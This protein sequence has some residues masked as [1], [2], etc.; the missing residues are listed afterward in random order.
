M[1][2]ATSSLNSQ[3]IPVSAAEVEMED[4]GPTIGTLRVVEAGTEETIS[5]SSD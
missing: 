1:S 2:P 4:V 5:T 3:E